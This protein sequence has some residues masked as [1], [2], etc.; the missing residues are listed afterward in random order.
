MTC[1]PEPGRA[2]LGGDHK[3]SGIRAEVCEEEGEQLHDH[4]PDSIVSEGPLVV[5]GGQSEHEHCHEV[6]V[7]QL[8]CEPSNLVDEG[9]REPVPLYSCYYMKLELKLMLNYAKINHTLHSTKHQLPHLSCQI[10]SA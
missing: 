2:D 8:Y 4:K 5:R 1:R 6:E 7:H 3:G 9:K 10:F